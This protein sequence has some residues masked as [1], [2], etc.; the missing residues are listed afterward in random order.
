MGFDPEVLKEA[1]Y[2]DLLATDERQ[3]AEAS[4]TERERVQA[5][6]IEE[7]ERELATHRTQAEQNEAAEERAALHRRDG[8]VPTGS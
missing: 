6:R 2:E 3:K 7:Q 8:E 4:M 1:V 5:R